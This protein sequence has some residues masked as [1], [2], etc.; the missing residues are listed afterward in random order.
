MKS[1]L[2]TSATLGVLIS[3]GL[4]AC[5]GVGMPTSPT[6]PA[7]GM[8]GATWAYSEPADEETYAAEWST[9]GSR[10][11]LTW[12]SDGCGPRLGPL[13]VDAPTALSAEILPAGHPCTTVELPFIAETATPAG[14][15][16][17]QPV[18]LTLP[19]GSVTIPP[20]AK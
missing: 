12:A 5:T 9:D 19:D 17:T 4:T 1:R 13:T 7:R 3:A 10:L 2:T 16:Q 14:V 15:D 8:D 20:I 6:S 11:I 18:E